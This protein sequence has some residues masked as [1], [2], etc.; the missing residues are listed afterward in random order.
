MAY[1]IKNTSGLLNTRLTDVGRRK[2]SQGNFVI[3]YFQI[4]DSEV[5]YDCVNDLNPK[6]G[7]IIEPPFNAQ[8]NVGTPESNKQNIKY[9]FKQSPTTTNTFGI[10]TFDSVVSPIYNSAAPRGFFKGGEGSWSANT[11]YGYLVTPNY[12]ID[13]STLTGGS[14]QIL[15]VSGTCNTLIPPTPDDCCSPTPT[16]TPQPTPTPIPTSICDTP[17]PTPYCTTGPSPGIGVPQVGDFVTIIYDCCGDCGKI[18]NGY[19]ILTYKICCLDNLGTTLTLDRDLPDFASLGFTGEA[20]VLIY[21]SEISDFYGTFT[22]NEITDQDLINYEIPCDISDGIIKIWNMNIPWSESPAGV[23]SSTTKDYTTYNSRTYLGSKEYFG[24]QSS[25]GQTFLNSEYDKLSSDTFYYNSFDEMVLLEPKNQ[26][27]VGLIHYTNNSVD[28]IY[29]EKFAMNP[30]DPTDEG[31]TG[32]AMNFKLEIP[33]LLWHKSTDGQIGETFYVDP[34]GYNKLSVNYMTSFKNDDMNDPGLRYYHLWDL[35]PDDNNNLNRVGKV[36][37]DYKMV[38]IDDEELIASMSY[39]SNRNWTLPTP[40]LSLTSPNICDGDAETTTG[41]LEN[42]NEYLWVTYRLGNQTA[43]AFTESLHC[44][45]Y[46]LIQGPKTGCTTNTQDVS[47]RFGPEFPFLNQPTGSCT[48]G[49][50]ADTMSILAQKVTGDTRPNPENWIEIDMTPQLTSTM[51]GG[52]I[53]QSGLTGTTFVVDVDSYTGGTSY[54]LNYLNLPPVNDN[55]ESCLNFGDEYYFYGNLKTDIQAT[56]YEM[57]YGVNLPN[58]QFTVSTNPTWSIEKKSYISEI[59]LYDENKDLILLTKLQSPQIRQGEQQ[60][61][62][63]LDF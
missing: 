22:P 33:W 56:I 46:T 13:I 30:V 6:N 54:V 57:R 26:K 51:I 25:S 5:C 43:S 2:L 37:P 8:N 11:D 36:F 52:Y 48:Y 18:R 17:A 49:F 47:I 20:R 42:D 62:I 38:I 7:Y 4:G 28:L 24:Y 53:T 19:T 39:K 27:S 15:L 9:P 50:F 10:G 32:Q 45:Y 1:I 29:G 23:F 55:G 12:Y 40:K 3:K 58:Q 31:A 35:N 44:N 63:K 34:P 60:F 21:P 16:P 61:L 59:G 41:I 14:N